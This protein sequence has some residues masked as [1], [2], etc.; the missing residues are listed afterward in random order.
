MHLFRT[1]QVGGQH[2]GL[3]AVPIALFL[4]LHLVAWVGKLLPRTKFNSGK[5]EVMER[6][7]ERVRTMQETTVNGVG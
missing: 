4:L 1:W 2:P 3:P 5:A 6:E 7:G